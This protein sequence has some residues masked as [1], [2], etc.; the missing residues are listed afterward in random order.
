MNYNIFF[1]RDAKNSYTGIRLILSPYDMQHGLY[2]FAYL[3][4]K[5]IY[6]LNQKDLNQ[7]QNN[8]NDKVP[9]ALLIFPLWETIQYDASAAKVRAHLVMVPNQ[10]DS[11]GRSSLLDVLLVDVAPFPGFIWKWFVF[12]KIYLEMFQANR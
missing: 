11:Y 1:Q 12:L 5:T 3:K 4:Q 2:Q 9:Q 10:P 6:P 7:N 8:D